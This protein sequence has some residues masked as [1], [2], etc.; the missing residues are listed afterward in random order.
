VL[1]KPFQDVATEDRDWALELKQFVY[2]LDKAWRDLHADW[3]RALAEENQLA[4][5]R[6]IAIGL[7]LDLLGQGAIGGIHFR[8]NRARFYSDVFRMLAGTLRVDLIETWTSYDQFVTR[9]LNP[10]FKF[11]EGVGIRLNTLRS[12]LHG[13][14]QSIQ[15]SAIVNQTEATRDNTVQLE[16]VLRE[17]RQLFLLGEEV[18]IRAQ[19][20]IVWW[21]RAAAIA[22]IVGAILGLAAKLAIDNW[23]RGTG[24]PFH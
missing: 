1:T 10:A 19:D 12:R 15:T 7:G 24:W 4:E 22:T 13:E 16:N 2:G 18:F 21:R 11:I 9:G 6:L 8:I 14:M 23:T 3:D 20:T 5:S 17:V